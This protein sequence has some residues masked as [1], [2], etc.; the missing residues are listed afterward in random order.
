MLMDPNVGTMSATMYPSN[1]LCSPAMPKKHGGRTRT[2]YGWSLPS[3]T[4]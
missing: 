3:L 2:R 1:I 4:T